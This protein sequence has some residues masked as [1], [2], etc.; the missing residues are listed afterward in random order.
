MAGALTAEA[1]LP[2]LPRLAQGRVARRRLV[3]C[4]HRPLLLHTRDGPGV[5]AQV[6]DVQCLTAS[7]EERQQFPRTQSEDTKRTAQGK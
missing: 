3:L 7:I 6:L 5:P 1:E 2:P 4:A